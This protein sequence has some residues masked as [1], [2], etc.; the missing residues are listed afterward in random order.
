MRVSART[1]WQLGFERSAAFVAAPT[2]N[3]VF[4]TAL[5]TLRGTPLELQPNGPAA[6]ASTAAQTDRK[7]GLKSSLAALAANCGH[8]STSKQSKTDCNPNPAVGA[9]PVSKPASAVRRI[10]LQFRILLE[11]SN[12]AYMPTGIE[13]HHA[14]ESIEAF[15]EKFPEALESRCGKFMRHPITAI[16][17][18]PMLRQHVVCS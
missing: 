3:A 18:Q 4:H 10:V 2:T 7:R 11:R 15:T 6:G 9:V 16:A 1:G 8:L 12:L 14:T 5:R 17:L 13:R